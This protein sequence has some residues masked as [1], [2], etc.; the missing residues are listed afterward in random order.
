MRGSTQVP[1]RWGRWVVVGTAVAVVAGC[2]RQHFRERAD[3]DI[4]GVISQKNI[5]PDW[6]VEN[7]HVYPDPRAR[8]ADAPD[9]HP[10]FPPYPPDD[11]AAWVTAPNP[12]HPGRGGAGRYEG[13]GYLDSLAAWDVQNRAEDTAEEQREKEPPTGGVAP[14]PGPESK[15]TP[16]TPAAAAVAGG[17]ASYL[18]VF[19]SQDR[20]FRIRLDQSVELA[21]FNSREFQD[22]REDLYLAALPVTLERY[23]FAA[24]AFASERIIRESIGRDVPGGGGEF[25][26]INTDA[27]FNRTFATGAELMVRLANQIVIDL[28]GPS[29]Q[30]SIS[31][32][33][34]TF[35]QPLL[36]GGGYAVT[37]EALTQ[38]ERTLLYAIRSFAR[39]RKVFYVAL[40]GVVGTGGGGGGGGADYTNNPYGLQ[41]LSTNLGRG[42]GANL[43]ARPTGFLP[44]ILRAASLANERKNVA[45]LENFL[46]LFQNLKEGGGVTDLQVAQVEQNMLQSRNTVLTLERLYLDNI[47][48]FKLQLGVPGTV[49][50]ELD[51]TPMRPVRRHLQRFDQLYLQM[52]ELAQLLGRYDPKVPPREFREQAGRLLTESSLARGTTFA[53]QYQKTAEDLRRLSDD[54]LAGQ[55]ANLLAQRRKLLDARAGRLLKG[56]PETPE[57]TA[58][59]DAVESRIDRL[60]F[61]QALRRYED[62]PWRGQPADRAAVEQANLFSAAFQA[63]FLVAAQ[64]RNERME[65]LRTGWPA[66]APL[67]VD[68]VDL[69]GVPY[70][71]ATARVAQAALVNRLDLMNARAQVVDS[72]RQVTVA[73]NALQGVFNVRYDLNTTT[74][75]DEAATFGFAGTRTRHTVTLDLEPPF[76]RRAE[77][78]QYRASLIGY[79]RSRRNLMAFEDNIVTDARVDLRQLRQLAVTYKIQ[80]RVVELAYAQVDNARST[81]LAPPDPTSARGAAGEAAALTQQL[82]TA[83]RSLL[84]SQND[85]YQAWLSYKSLRMNLYLDLELLTLDARGIWIDEPLPPHPTDGPPGRDPGPPEPGVGQRPPDPRPAPPPPR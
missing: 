44:T 3:K 81:L 9:A 27:G 12:Q 34:L 80:Q 26:R 72:W 45:A 57:Q 83:Q 28:S 11:Y 78:N 54:A 36:R 1:R 61:E 42:I 84:G 71:E 41:G 49:A 25:W 79:E 82:L 35:V 10:D 52:H 17:T 76:V 30:T 68:G 85:L 47:D 22:R 73:A 29:P 6:K 32:L 48:F 15:D 18:Q 24:Q 2:S 53:Q 39:F 5:F 69:L 56:Q 37:L 13:T 64:I 55:L 16:D 65:R 20:P 74:P 38:A 7:W 21:L 43:T 23:G 63:G 31:N 8:F 67:T 46:L 75:R 40:T 77:R 14:T 50:L 59:A 58:E 62:Q 4:E 66:L 19:A 51:D 60:R 33:S 70:D